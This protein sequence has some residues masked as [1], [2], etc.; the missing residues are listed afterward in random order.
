MSIFEMITPWDASVLEAI[1]GIKCEFLDTFM[2]LMSFLGDKGL[3]WIAIGLTLC[4][5]KKTRATGVMVLCAMVLGL[6]LGEFGIKNIICRPRPFVTYPELIVN[7][8]MPSGYSFPSGHTTSSFAAATV[9]FIRS[10]KLAIPASLLAFLI[11]FS[12]LYNCAHYPTDVICGAVLG[13]V[14]AIITCLIFKK[15]GWDNRLGKNIIRKKGDVK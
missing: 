2:A 15:L 3:I 14:L 5:F 9:I 4:F 6:L 12:R 10:K 1:Q 8:P 13:I 11:A 7:G